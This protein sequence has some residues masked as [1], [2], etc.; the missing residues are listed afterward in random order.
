MANVRRNLIEKLDAN[1]ENISV[2][3]T[4]Q[5]SVTNKAYT[6]NLNE[7]PSKKQQSQ[8]QQKKNG[9]PYKF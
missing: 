1:K 7:L 5:L 8:F 4:S 9:L 3:T 2:N 6:I